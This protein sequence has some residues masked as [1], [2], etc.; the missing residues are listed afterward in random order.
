MKILL[1]G[2]SGFLGT[3]LTSRLENTHELHHLVS[4]LKDHEKVEKEVLLANPDIII[5]L[6]A[7]T[8]VQE[9]FVEQTEFSQVNYVGTVNLI[10]SAL[11]LPNL[12]NFLFS[13][14]MEVYGWQPISDEVKKYGVPT[15]FVY[16]NED[17]PTNPNCPY[18]V[19][20]VGC[21]NYLKYVHR[22]F[23][24]PFVA[25]RQTNTYGR[26]KNDYFV[27]EQIITQMLRNKEE[28]S[29]GYAEPYRNFMYVSDMIDMWCAVIE[30]HEKC[31]GKIFTV[32]PDNAIKIK[33]Y[34]NI[35]AEKIGW[36]GKIVWDSK[37]PRPGEIYWLCS[38][39]K[40]IKSITGWHPKVTLSDGL[41]KTI[42]TWKKKV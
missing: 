8:E 41:D 15:E 27:T 5:H 28:I 16:F 37:P 12:K 35:I 25:I 21:E 31:I 6:A 22:S 42:E 26:D 7:R 11:K 4:D 18:A 3:A 32:G 33:D 36:K 2:S 39:Y 1:T 23:G 34:A 9:S 40:S 20:K 13:S 17:T 24:F 30:Q 14:T 10:E 19:A 29:L 38:D